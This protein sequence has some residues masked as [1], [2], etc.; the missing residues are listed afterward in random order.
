MW[1]KVSFLSVKREFFSQGNSIYEARA[2]PSFSQSDPEDNYIFD[3]K[4]SYR[5]SYKCQ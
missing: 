3:I 5:L 1:Y 2:D 4:N